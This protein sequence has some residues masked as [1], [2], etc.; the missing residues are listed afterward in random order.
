MK[1]PTA[2]RLRRRYVND[3]HPLVVLRFEDGHEI[4][5]ARGQGKEF[6]AYQGETIKVIALYD[7]SSAEREV[8]DSRKAEAFDPA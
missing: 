2:T 3:A 6:D 5:V 7:P 8:L 1:K 4:R